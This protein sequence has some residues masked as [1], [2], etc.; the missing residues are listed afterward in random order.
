M[1]QIDHGTV[2]PVFILN[3]LSAS[4]PL[5]RPADRLAQAVLIYM[6]GLPAEKFND[7]RLARTLE[8][9]APHAEAVGQEVVQ[10]MR[11]MDHPTTRPGGS[12]G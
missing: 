10:G 1:A 2:A 3:R 5:Y 6:L 11:T 4:R 7:N 12:A 9:I 8:A